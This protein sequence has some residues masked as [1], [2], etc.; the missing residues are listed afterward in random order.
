MKLMCGVG[1]VR[2]NVLFVHFPIINGFSES[3]DC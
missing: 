2:H 3:S 1:K